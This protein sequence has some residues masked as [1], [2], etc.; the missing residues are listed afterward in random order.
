MTGPESEVM[1]GGGRVI[2]L[3]ENQ[4]YHQMVQSAQSAG[5]W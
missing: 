1:A 3:R 2:E 4:R 5:G